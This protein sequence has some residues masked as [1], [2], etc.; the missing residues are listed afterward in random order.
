MFKR[1][2]KLLERMS[3]RPE[4]RYDLSKK[5]LSVLLSCVTGILCGY[6]TAQLFELCGVINQAPILSVFPVFIGFAVG[7]SM[8]LLG[9]KNK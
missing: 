2:M 8:T 9:L 3:A 4:Q 5:A 7:T 6:L 1:T